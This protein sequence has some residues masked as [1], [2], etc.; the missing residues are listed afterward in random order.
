MLRKTTKQTGKHVNVGKCS[1]LTNF[2]IIHLNTVLLSLRFFVFKR[3][4]LHHAASILLRYLFYL[5]GL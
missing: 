2:V 1:A 4:V 5:K 3:T